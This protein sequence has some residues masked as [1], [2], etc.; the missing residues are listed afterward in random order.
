M[1]A[2]RRKK[3]FSAKCVV[4][5]FGAGLPTPPKR[6]TEGLLHTFHHGW[7]RTNN[8]SGNEMIDVHEKSP[9][10]V[11]F[12]PRG[13]IISRETWAEAHATSTFVGHVMIGILLPDAPASS[14]PLESS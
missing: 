4:G 6:L 9:G 10:S 13:S 5:L 3:R 2:S 11:G 1:A 12:S 7:R 8:I 14:A